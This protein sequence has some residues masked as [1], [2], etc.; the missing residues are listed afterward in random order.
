[1]TADVPAKPLGAAL[2]CRAPFIPPYPYEPLLPD[3]QP[4]CPARETAP[5]R[6]APHSRPAAATAVIKAHEPLVLERERQPYRIGP[7]ED[8]VARL[9]HMA[10]VA[11]SR[12]GQ[13]CSTLI[14][15]ATMVLPIANSSTPALPCGHAQG[16]T[17]P[18]AG[19]S[20]LV[21]SH[22]STPCAVPDPT[23]LQAHDAWSIHF[24]H[25]VLCRPHLGSSTD[26]GVSDGQSLDMELLGT[27]YALIA[28]QEKALELTR[29]AVAQLE[30]QIGP[31]REME[32]KE[33]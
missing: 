25:V 6:A 9:E 18:A 32:R 4:P 16:A 13:D 8:L 17:D 31:G 24:N 26:S 29:L 5:V 19:P 27:L 14:R 12:N 3:Q 1:M 21:A 15:D 28:A 20:A 11:A 7:N 22:A 30:Q 2:A 33:E 23:D 10:Q